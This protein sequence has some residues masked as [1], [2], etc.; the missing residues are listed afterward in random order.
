MN[1]S[2]L[3]CLFTQNPL[4]ALILTVGSFF[5]PILLTYLTFNKKCIEIGS[6][7]LELSKKLS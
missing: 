1:F 5:F 7:N 6:E 2:N 4:L 3:I